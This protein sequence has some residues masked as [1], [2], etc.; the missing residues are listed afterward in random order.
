M[1]F[2]QI[3]IWAKEFLGRKGF[4]LVQPFQVGWYNSEIA[5]TY[6]LPNPAEDLGLLIGNTKLLWKPFMEFL[7]TQPSTWLMDNPHP[8]D[9]YTILVMEDMR[10]FLASKLELVDSNILVRYTFNMGPKMVAFQH[11]AHH[12]GLAFHNTSCGLNLHR[13]FGP[14]IALRAILV[15]P[16][17]VQMVKPVLQDTLT[18]EQNEVVAMETKSLLEQKQFNWRDWAN[19]RRHV[20][21]FMDTDQHEYPPEMMEYH[22]TKNMDC[23]LV[24]Q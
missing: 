23:L 16:L 21:A 4:T 8:L 12:A 9:T 10:S 18:T 17:A 11:C 6:R 3:T 2:K 15:V 7:S 19:M 14:W 22:Y 24:H 13:E 5:E 1:S 20:S